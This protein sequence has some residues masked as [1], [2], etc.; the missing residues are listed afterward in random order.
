MLFEIAFA[1]CLG[2]DFDFV[3]GAD[4][5]GLCRQRQCC[6]RDGSGKQHGDGRI[7]VG[8]RVVRVVR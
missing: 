6:R 3:Q 1:L 2:N 7:P 4:R 8:A 5:E